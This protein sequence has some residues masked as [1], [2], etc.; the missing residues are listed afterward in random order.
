MRDF[1]SEASRPSE[2]IDEERRLFLM[3]MLAGH[4]FFEG[5]MLLHYCPTDC[6]AESPTQISDKAI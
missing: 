6:Q 5:M 3:R 2:E 1:E 4:S